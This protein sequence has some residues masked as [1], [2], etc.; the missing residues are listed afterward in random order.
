MWV[1]PMVLPDRG[2]SHTYLA[3][4]GGKRSRVDLPTWPRGVRGHLPVWLGESQ[5]EKGRV[6]H[7][8]T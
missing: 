1:L 3:G 4:Q 6:G 8:F 2:S 5:G 7:P